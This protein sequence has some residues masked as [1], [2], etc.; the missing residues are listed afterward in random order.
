MAAVDAHGDP[1][2]AA[3]LDSIKRTR[4]AL[5]GPLT[6]PVGGGYRSVNVALRQEFDLYANVRPTK[7]IVRGGRYEG[8]DLVLIR[9][10][11]EGLYVGLDHTFRVGDDPKAVAQATSVMTREGYA[12]MAERIERVRGALPGTQAQVER[13][14]AVTRPGG[15]IGLLLPSGLA[16]DRGCRGLRRVQTGRVQNY[17]LGIA[18]GNFANEMTSL[19]MPIAP[20]LW[21]FTDEAIVERTM[22]GQ[23]NELLLDQLTPD[24]SRRREVEEIR[25]AAER[26]VVLTR[27]LLDE[28]LSLPSAVLL[29]TRKD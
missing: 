2:P 26:A 23:A 20:G 18:I 14:L 29:A 24:D 7:S 3:T 21:Q 27:Q 22:Q 15:R 5:K 13:A 19:Y 11:T 16:T 8:I 25:K 10:N 17:A 1:L 12:A 9:E 28:F 4:L 6:T